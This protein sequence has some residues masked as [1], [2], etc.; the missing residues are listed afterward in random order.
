MRN[1]DTRKTII[2]AAVEV[3]A[4]KGYEKA[5]VDEIAAR[6]QVAKGTVFYSFKSKEDIFFAIIEYGTR[7][8]TEFVQSRSSQG[9]N[10][11]ERLDM[12]YQAAFEFF[13]QY[14]SFCTVLVSELWRIQ[15]KWNYEPTDLLDAYKR[16]ME[17]IFEEGQQLGEFRDD[18][19]AEDLGLI[20]FFLAAISSLSKTLSPR[21]D[22]SRQLADK[23]KKIFFR[24]LAKE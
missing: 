10:A 15:S 1:Q 13:E 23:A 19:S 2:D 22:A 14:N 11:N 5:T 20:V 17:D 24:G 3:F 6:A 16:Q 8:F 9:A 4:Q 12:A 18:F 21:R 7:T